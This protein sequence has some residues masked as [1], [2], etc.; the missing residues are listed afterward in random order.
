[1]RDAKIKECVLNSVSELVTDLVYYDRKE[2][3]ELTY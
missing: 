3:E 2:D 1:M